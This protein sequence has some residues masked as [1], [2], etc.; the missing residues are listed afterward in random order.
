MILKESSTVPVVTYRYI[1]NPVSLMEGMEPY[2]VMTL[3]VNSGAPIIS[4][5]KRKRQ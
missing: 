5:F 2:L 3:V 1:R 4:D